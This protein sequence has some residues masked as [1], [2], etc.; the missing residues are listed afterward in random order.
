MNTPICDFVNDFIK[1]KPHRLHMPGHKGKSFLDFEKYDITEID[2][3]DSLYEAD[4]IIK[5]SE[6][7]ASA[8]FDA[9]TFYSTEGSSQ[10]IKAMLHLVCMEKK[11]KPLIWAGRNVHKSFL[12]SAVLTDFEIK[13][14]YPE[15]DASYLS[16]RIDGER[17]RKVRQKARCSLCNKP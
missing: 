11:T 12:S 2:G 14:L 4:G 16:C 13:W 1:A 3:A 15:N 7:N 6:K 8:L 10:C 17:L 9:V 5:E